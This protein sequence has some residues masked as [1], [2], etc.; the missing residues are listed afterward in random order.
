MHAVVAHAGVAK[1]EHRFD[2]PGPGGAVV[3]SLCDDDL[4]V[5]FL[6]P[7]IALSLRDELELALLWVVVAV[8]ARVRILQPKVP[9]DVASTLR[10]HPRQHG[11]KTVEG[12]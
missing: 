1:G 7:G 9:G 10:L 5:Q 3:V 6:S 8:L 4:L 2:L 11:K 12:V